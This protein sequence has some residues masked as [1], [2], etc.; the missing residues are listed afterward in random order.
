MSADNENIS[1]FLTGYLTRPLAIGN[2]TIPTRLVLAPM[3][4]LGNIAFRELLA[5]FGGYGLLFS[6]MCS[7]KRIRHENRWVS[8]YFRWRDEERSQ[9]VWQIFGNDPHIMA[10]AARRIES[11]GF[12]GVDIN[13][14]CAVTDICRQMGGAALLKHPVL[15]EKIVYTVRR[16][17]K[18]PV[19]VKFRTGWKDDPD[20]AVGFAKRFERAGA[21]ALTYHPRV[22]PDR[23]SRRAKWDYIGKV[24]NAVS[25]PV[26]GNGD[27]F[28]PADCERM[29]R[30][31]HCDGVAVGRMAVVRPWLFAR[32]T[33][34]FTPNR[35]L[36]LETSLGLY[37]LLLKYFDEKAALQR[38]QKFAMYFCANF[39][40]GHSL[41]TKIRN[42]KTQE[43]AKAALREFFDSPPDLITHPNLNLLL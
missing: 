23:R 5:G 33:G 29:I 7:A 24:K 1:P 38:F 27:V 10:D 16:A 18:S 39:K 6:E 9:L 13:F 21:D 26:F 8:P 41:F 14:G 34:G 20:A 35:A 36:F 31:T 2:Q 3:A 43:T 40:F 15:A 11:E 37:D 32:W 19:F 28:L 17:V 25:I 4:L 12:F 30:T 42:A 22:A